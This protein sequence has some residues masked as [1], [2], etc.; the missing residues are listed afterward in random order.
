MNPF[1]DGALFDQFGGDAMALS[2]LVLVDQLGLSHAQ[3]EG[4]SF[5]RGVE[6]GDG[7]DREALDTLEIDGGVSRLVFQL[8][9]DGGRLVLRADLLLDPDPFLGS[10]KF[11]L[12]YETPEI[13]LHE[14]LHIRHA[15]FKSRLRVGENSSP[16]S[17]DGR[18]TRRGLLTDQGICESSW[19]S[20]CY[21]ESM[22]E[23]IYDNSRHDPQM[24]PVEDGVGVKV[25]GSCGEHS[26]NLP[27]EDW[28]PSDLT[29]ANLQPPL[30]RLGAHLELKD[31]NHRPT[32]YT[33]I[34]FPC[35]SL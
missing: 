20:L 16:S 15:S 31:V 11:E 32:A 30:L 3:G 14:L 21:G 9:E 7:G 13:F 29:L 1:L 34:L 25:P 4:E 24:L 27:T 8:E 17:R 33:T 28:I 26:S 5:P 2:F 6:V 10:L 19:S 12:L 23:V 22:E 35:L 18:L